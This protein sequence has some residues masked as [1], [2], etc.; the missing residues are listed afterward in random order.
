MDRWMGPV[1]RAALLIALALAGRIELSCADSTATAAIPATAA[2]QRWLEARAVQRAGR[3][4]LQRGAEKDRIERAAAAAKIALEV[5]EKAKSERVVGQDDLFKRMCA[6]ID[7]LDPTQVGQ[8]SR[9]VVALPPEPAMT[10]AKALRSWAAY[11]DP[12]CQ[13]LVLP[14]EKLGQ[15]ALD[16]G[17]FDI[18][19]DCLDQVL[20]FNPD[21]PGLRKTL[22]FTKAGGRWYGPK[23]M[24]AVRSGL[25]WDDKLGW[26]VAKEAAR[27]AKGDYFDL[28]EKRWTTLEAAEGEHATLDKEWR[29]LTEHLEISGNAPL[30]DLIDVANRLEEFYG[31]IFASY[32]AFFAKDKS[33]V[34]LI[35]GLLDH[36]RLLVSVA[37]DKADYR[38]SLPTGVDPGWT[39]GMWIPAVGSSFFYAGPKEV[40]YH[41]F[42]HQILH[43]FSHGNQSPAWLCEGVAVYTQ[44]PHFDRNGAM[45]L[46]VLADNRMIR[47]YF[48]QRKAGTAITLEQ[49]MALTDGRVWASASDPSANYPAAGAL[50]QFCMEGEG[51][52][53]RADFI[54]FLRDSYL[55]TIMGRTLPDYLNLNKQAFAQAYEKWLA[56]DGAY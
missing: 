10:D 47:N 13:A 1:L 40:I 14:T 37:K 46:G 53:Y 2:M 32:A 43:V 35:F 3:A 25:Q 19:H 28:Q 36:D 22:N 20:T 44:S 7:Y 34:K 16:F 5:V 30:H 23:D 55:G 8:V 15:K 18:A 24:E 38:K 4:E 6:F 21:N 9:V 48:T 26:I 27:Y 17:V 52:R 54:D 56:N 39:A 49:I 33:D 31:Q 51:R 11:A 41:E 42:T 12:K 29:I 50:V 45:Q